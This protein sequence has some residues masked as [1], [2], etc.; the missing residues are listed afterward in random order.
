[1]SEVH[2]DIQ[3]LV[4]AGKLPAAIAPKVSTL[5]PGTYVS[6]KSWG[7]GQVVEWDLLGERMLVNFEGGRNGHAIKLEFSAKTLDA[8]G[9]NHFL[10]RRFQDK[11]A[12]YKE[13]TENPA[14]FMKNVLESH[15][16]R[17][18]IELFEDAVRVKVVPEAKFKTWW[19]NTKKALRGNPQF[20]IPSKRNLPLELRAGEFT[21][22]D[23][24]KQDVIGSRDL[25]TKTKALE[26]VIKESALFESTP[27]GLVE[28]AAHVEETAQQNLKLKTAEAIELLLFRDDLVA[29]VPTL[30]DTVKLTLAGALGEVQEKLADFIA[31]LSAGKQNRVFES[32]SETHGEEWLEKATAL[33]NKLNQRSLTEVVKVMQK[34]G[35]EEKLKAWFKSNISRRNLSSEALAW[36]CKERKGLAKDIFTHEIA[37][38]LMNA[39][40]RDHFDDDKKSNRVMD[41][42]VDDATLINDL[43]AK[44]D[45]T[46]VNNFARQVMLSSAFEELSKR[47]VM[48]RIIR[49]APEVQEMVDAHG[50]EDSGPQ[51][52][53]IVSWPSLEAR[54]KA[55]D[56]LVN[57]E[58]PKN[59]EDISIARSYGDLRENF[60]YKSAKEYQR[61]L[62]RRK[63]ESERDLARAQGTDFTEFTADVVGIATIVGLRDTTADTE[64]EYTILGAWDGD[65]AN[66]IISYLKVV[67]DVVDLPSEESDVVRT[68][69]IKSLRRWEPATGA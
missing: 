16:G 29:K 25:K 8:I 62:M 64:E 38:A 59:R 43:I 55:F 10:A 23:A 39:V 6:S 67:G 14:A 56:H 65:P 32:L 13:S 36:V 19:D 51:E 33:L 27:E 1:M 2:P 28:L 37:S 24:L 54:K 9:D 20:I 58:I 34:V 12:L 69:Q 15:G 52:A 63:M 66:Q 5:T 42:L 47:S 46:L 17:L 18:A 11:T 53:L 7:G 68:V 57:V 3:N 50:E 45:P 49:L 31:G 44:A 26:A 30:K 22:T 40:E 61:V 21:P 4:L 60:E 41:V 35:G 48:A